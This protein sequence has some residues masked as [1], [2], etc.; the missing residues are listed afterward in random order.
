MATTMPSEYTEFT[1]VDGQ[2]I[3]AS[4]AGIPSD[5]DQNAD[6]VA[7]KHGRA[8][9][10]KTVASRLSNLNCF[11]HHCSIGA[12][13]GSHTASGQG[14]PRT[15]GQVLKAWGTMSASDKRYWTEKAA[16]ERARLNAANPEYVPYTRPS[17]AEP[18]TGTT[19]AR[20]K[21]KRA[22]GP[23]SWISRIAIRII[24]CRSEPP[25]VLPLP[26][27]AISTPAL[28]DGHTRR[29]PFRHSQPWSGVTWP[30]QLSPAT[31]PCPSPPVV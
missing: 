12:E 8:A 28:A 17:R 22:S 20:R 5:P 31:N 7:G 10:K 13:W 9:A 6:D 30:P 1:A 24:Y 11:M 25:P 18:S 16:V 26:S 14:L 2:A 23:L 21:K 19:T 15:V 3:V 4:G 29:G 27:T